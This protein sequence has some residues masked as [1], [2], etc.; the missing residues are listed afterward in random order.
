MCP[1]TKS[2]QPAC[3]MLTQLEEVD[4]AQGMDKSS[5]RYSDM[6]VILWFFLQRQMIGFKE[7]ESGDKCKLSWWS[8]YFNLLNALPYF[9]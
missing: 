3:Q 8:F 4:Y 6:D 2:L 9:L 5:H 7:V 1:H